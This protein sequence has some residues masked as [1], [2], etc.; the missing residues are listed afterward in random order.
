MDI[1]SFLSGNLLSGLKDIIGQFVTDPTKKAELEQ[2]A[3]ELAVKQAAIIEETTQKEIEAKQAIMTAE[4][5][6]GDNYTKRARPTIIYAGLAAMFVNYVFLPWLA[7]F[8]KGAA[9]PA[10]QVP[11]IF[12]QVWAGVSGL[13]VLGR[14]CEKTGVTL[15]FCKPNP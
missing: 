3:R 11:D 4:L 6:Q 14:T 7:F 2:A 15:P 8:S 10:I 12:W 5:T 1:A 9:L 13:Y